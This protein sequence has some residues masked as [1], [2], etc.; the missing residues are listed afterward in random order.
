MKL[1]W[2]FALLSLMISGTQTLAF[3]QGNLPPKSEAFTMLAQGNESGIEQQHFEI[4]KDAVAFQKLWDLN[5]QTVSPKPPTPKVD[6]SNEMVIAAFAG[7]KNTG[8]FELKLTKINNYSD[9][10][11]IDLSLLA[12][13]GDCMVSGAL[14][15][16]FVFVKTIKFTDKPVHFNLELKTHACGAIK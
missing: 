12:P 2:L 16:P 13:D 8:G 4:I 3:A 6:F 10:L 5:F 1:H 14:T 15:Q 7:T 11:Q 9:S